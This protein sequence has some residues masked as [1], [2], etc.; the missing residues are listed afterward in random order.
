MFLSIGAV[1]FKLSLN[2]S[3][4]DGYILSTLLLGSVYGSGI[5]LLLLKNELYLFFKLFSFLQPGMD[6]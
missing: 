6:S 4:S 5:S 2:D 3:F 1:S